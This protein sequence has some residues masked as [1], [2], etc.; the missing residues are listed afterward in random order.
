MHRR[1]P[2]AEYRIGGD[3]G[4]G[5]VDRGSSN[6]RTTFEQ[7]KRVQ[8]DARRSALSSGGREGGILSSLNIVRT[9]FV[10]RVLWST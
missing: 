3:G 8:R 5:G 1:S 9:F 2:S 7:S 4:G 6:V 10:G